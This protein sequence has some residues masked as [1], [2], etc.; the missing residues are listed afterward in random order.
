MIS[1]TPDAMFDHA[2]FEQKT[3]SR[4]QNRR[5]S[6]NSG[7]DRGLFY[8]GRFSIDAHAVNLLLGK[9]CRGIVKRITNK[10]HAIIEFEGIDTWQ[11]VRKSE[12]HKLEKMEA[13]VP[14]NGFR[15]MSN[16]LGVVHS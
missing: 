8:R 1:D 12:F 16:V 5:T 11:G 10:G 15:I 13:T 9:G 4:F 2:N 6:T 3:K 14:P 7:V